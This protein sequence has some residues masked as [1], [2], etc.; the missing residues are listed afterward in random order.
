MDDIECPYCNKSFDICNDDGHGTED[1]TTYEEQCPHCEKYFVFTSSIMFHYS[2]EKA[3]CL[4]GEPHKYKKV[5]GF[6]EE[7][8]KDLFRCEYCAVERELRGGIS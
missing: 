4:N 3:P 5:V 7:A 1:G 6:P 2:P 8:F